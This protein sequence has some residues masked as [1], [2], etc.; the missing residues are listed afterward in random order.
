MVLGWRQE[1]KKT[2]GVLA[3][4]GAQAKVKPMLLPIAGFGS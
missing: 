1:E 2:D 4:V 3:G